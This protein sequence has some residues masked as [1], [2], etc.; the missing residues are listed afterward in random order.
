MADLSFALSQILINCSNFIPGRITLPLLLFVGHLHRTVNVCLVSCSIQRATLG[1][2]IRHLKQKADDFAH[3]IMSPR[4]TTEDIR[5]FHR[6]TYIPSMRYGLA[7]IAVDEQALESVQSRALQSMLKHL[8]I[9]STIPTAIRHGPVEFGGL[10]LYDLRT[11]AGIEA[12]KFLRDSVYSGSENGKLI[13]MN[14]QY[15]QLEAGISEPLLLNPGILVSYLTPS[16]L[17]SLRQFLY[18]HNLTVDISEAYTPNIRG[19]TDQLIMQQCHLVRYTPIQQRDINLVRIYLQLSTLSEMSDSTK[20]GSI[21]LDFLDAI[22]PRDFTASP[23]W[24]R[25][26]TPTTAHRKLWKGYL[27]SSFLRYVPYWKIDPSPRTVTPAVPASVPP[28]FDSIHA[29][30]GSLSRPHRRLLDDLQLKSTEDQVWKAFRSRR[31]LI[32]ATDGGL[33]NQRGTFG[34]I[35]STGTQSLFTCAGPVEGPFDTSSSTRSDLAGYASAVL[36]L[37]TLSKFWGFKFRVNFKWFCDSRAA[38]SRVDDS[39]RVSPFD[40][41]L[42]SLIQS[43][44]ADLRHPIRAYWVKAHQDNGNS[45]ARL[46]V[47]SSLNIMRI[48]WLPPIDSEVDSNQDN[49]QSICLNKLFYLCQ[50]VA[51]DQPI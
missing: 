41:D 2:R 29:Y 45:S 32:L 8:G 51:I 42:L 49:G 24:P 26:Q 13:L 16:W 21:R 14:L 47:A 30:I 11:E 44:H 1:G 37:R 28:S 18:C 39:A 7:A 33:A 46:S 4:L 3:R 22:R 23:L 27:K 48:T 40:A 38:I 31:K 10:G 9:Q 36:F 6:S 34:W 19:P 50:W 35:L 25:Q 17:M 15:S 20:R 5:I 43:F 12:L